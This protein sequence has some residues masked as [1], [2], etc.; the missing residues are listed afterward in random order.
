MFKYSIFLT[1]FFYSLMTYAG[2]LEDYMSAIN[3]Q[4]PSINQLIIK[5]SLIEIAR[6]QACNSSFTNLLLKECPQINCS[7]LLNNWIS[8]N[9]TN[10]GAVIGK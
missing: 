2:G 10:S 9:N 6:S 7:T 5:K 1:I 3:N 8:F 4:C